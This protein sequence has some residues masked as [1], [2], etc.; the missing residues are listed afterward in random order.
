MEVRSDRERGILVLSLEGRLDMQGALDFEELIR[1][2]VRGPDNAVVL[3][4]SG[5]SYLSSA[6]IRAIVRLEKILKPRGGGLHI[7]GVQPYALSVLELTGFSNLL[8]LHSTP[9]EA[10]HAARS[11]LGPTGRQGETEATLFQVR[12][13]EF[14]VTRNE[15]GPSILMVTGEELEGCR[16]EEELLQVTVSTGTWSFG[17]GAPGAAGIPGDLITIGNVAVWL[18]EGEDTPDY[19]V[20]DL[21]RSSI[22]LGASFLISPAE[23]SQF[24]VDVKPFEAEEVLITDLLDAL[25]EIVGELDAG[26]RGVL[27]FS[28]CAESPQIARGPGV[29]ESSTVLLAGC[30]V[31]VAPEV[32]HGGN[33]GSIA[34]LL[35]RRNI[36]RIMALALSDLAFMKERSIPGTLEEGLSSGAAALHH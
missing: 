25:H 19:L 15:A 36:P 33:P 18:P 23:P 6:G 20:V 11:V 14:R 24:T 1:E 7:A 12:G 2:E 4:M 32:E 17:W 10:V 26:Y 5:V 8:S 35:G 29:E 21:K 13:A 30:G 34:E 28:F 31:S 27:G 22:P 9:D 3:D 16:G